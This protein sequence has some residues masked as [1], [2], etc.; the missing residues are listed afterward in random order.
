MYMVPLRSKGRMPR[1]S[2]CALPLPGRFDLRVGVFIGL[3]IFLGQEVEAQTLT[4]PPNTT[5]PPGSTYNGI[6]INAL[7]SITATGLTISPGNG[8]QTGISAGTQAMPVN[9]PVTATG[10]FMSTTVNL[11]SNGGVQGIFASGSG[12]LV[13]LGAGS[14]VVGQNGGGNYGV[15]AGNGG[16]VTLIDGAFVNIAGGGGNFPIATYGGGIFDMTGGFVTVSNG[17]GN[18]ILAGTSNFGG[19]NFAG[20]IQMNGTTINMLGSNGG[21]TGLLAN[22]GSTATLTNVTVNLSGNGGG[23]FGVQSTG[24][25]TVAMAGG[26]V[27]VTATGG[28]NIGM[29][30]SGANSVATLNGTSVTVM[31]N[32]S[33]N[34]AV[35]VTNGGQLTATD[36][37]IAVIAANSTAL[38]LNNSGTASMTGGSVTTNGAG[39]QAILVSGTGQNNGTFDGTAVSSSNGFGIVANDSMSSTL[40]F[41]NGASLVGGNGTLL[42]NQT[43]SG[44]SIVNLNATNQV[45]LQGDVNAAGSAGM[46][47]VTLV[48]QSTLTGAINANT[49]TGAVGINPAQ[50]PAGLPPE[51]VNVNIDSSSAWNMAASST[52]GTLNVAAGAHISFL[53]PSPGF[54]TLAL[55]KLTGSGGVF[56]MDVN[57]PARQGDLLT[58]QTLSQGNHL[59]N[60]F[61]R[62]Q[63]ADLPAETALL[64]VRTPDGG[65]GFS[66]EIDGGTYKYF[67][68]HGDGSAVTPN[69][70]DWYLVRGD[71]INPNPP[72]GPIPPPELLDP[73]QDLTNTAN[74]AIGTSSAVLP[75]FYGD[76]NPVIEQMQD[77]RLK[78]E[79]AG[80]EPK[81]VAAPFSE[82]WIKGF[83]SN[84]RI[85][86]EASRVFDQ[87]LAGMQIGGD[88]R[89]NLGSDQLYLGGFAGYFHGWRDFHDGGT[90]G[91]DAFS[92]GLYGEWIHPCN[93]Y[94]NLV[95]KQTY[96]WNNFSTPTD[97]GMGPTA[98]ADSS[99]PTL[100]GL[101]E[102][103]KRW[104]IG[105]VFLEPQARLEGAW[106]DGVSYTASNGLIVRQSDESS[107]RGS[108]ELR[109]GWHFECRD[110]TVFEPYTRV[111]IV[112]EFL[113]QD[114]VETNDTTFYPKLGGLSIEASAGLSVKVDRSLYV[115]SEYQYSSSID[116]DRLSS[117]WAVD[118]GLRVL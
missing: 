42:L 115:Y 69:P 76:M 63:S 21:T 52:V 102:I 12:A 85:N 97:D 117:P 40:A 11:G 109:Q 1:V 50:P 16:T 38:Q 23:N 100:G 66:G 78:C 99:M 59:L 113:G 54:T 95:L 108:L 10:N 49:L 62:N 44:G 65:A 9:S 15:V 4:V 26:S 67:V 3:V 47:N 18:G 33:G 5:P 14:S 45:D 73:I 111:A 41:S 94:A 37:D 20:T 105:P 89:F 68:V 48:E 13:T 51:N 2:I 61:N 58:I 92:A 56:T 71:E 43:N 114:E 36:S 17:G 90:G 77:L 74:A 96:L 8:V 7:G 27:N 32:S 86:N 116:S 25:A 118:A 81:G 64:V 112:N 104:D 53:H 31:N 79:E 101:L 24:G 57:L 19:A 55:N 83:G 70:N 84:G 91:T 39:G 88:R 98:T 107:L 30:I 93:W 6:V 87:D 72:S 22:F 103:G 110:G 60:I 28:G 75:L 29:L 46:T 34:F 80:P 82:L 106:A 35:Q